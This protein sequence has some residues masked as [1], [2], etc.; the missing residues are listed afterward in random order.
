MNKSARHIS[1]KLSQR[2][3]YVVRRGG[4]ASSVYLDKDGRWN[5]IGLAKRFTTQEAAKKFYRR[6]YGGEN[7]GI[8]PA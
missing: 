4:F 5:R 3:G 7:F 6:H 2:R 1:K 8:F